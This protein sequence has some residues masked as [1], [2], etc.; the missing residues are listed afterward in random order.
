[1]NAAAA[2]ADF[3]VAV[4]GAGPAGVATATGLARLGW[5]VCV[6]TAA[7]REG[8]EGASERTLELLR[9][10]GLSSALASITVRGPRLRDWAGVQ[11]ET[12]YE[13]RV[14]RCR[15][16][17][18]LRED[19][20]AVAELRLERVRTVRREGTAWV[21]QTESGELRVRA[22]VEARGR[23]VRE[24][25]QRGPRLLS[26]SHRYRG[27]GEAG[28]AVFMGA[29]AWYW[30]A[31]DGAGDIQLQMVSAPRASVDARA[32][33]PRATSFLRAGTEMPAERLRE[34]SLPS[35]LQ[36]RLGAAR[37]L[38]EVRAC[39]AGASCRA[40]AEF[41]GRV[42]AGDAALALEPLSGHGLYEALVGAPAVVA[43][44]NTWLRGEPWAPVR[45]FLS[46]RVQESWGR[47]LAA[48]GSFYAEAAAY[49][50]TAFWSDT[51]RGYATL[52]AKVVARAA[53]AGDA[54]TPRVQVRP[55]LNGSRIEQ[56]R[57]LVG[58]SWPRGIWCH[59]DIELAALLDSAERADWDETRTAMQLGRTPAAVHNVLQWLK[60]HDALPA[61]G[62]R[63]ALRA[64]VGMAFAYERGST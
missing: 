47:K 5:S 59:G 58:A 62:A 48:A 56:R 54:A 22:L 15:F 36:Q 26:V 50:D 14:E 16:D 53:P 25:A 35:A 20:R 11:A 64:G 31:C 38:G 6:L 17:T 32:E 2:R 34:A 24:A 12:G 39:A 57:V 43:A 27:A 49:C 19:A 7:P 30:L 28:S 33:R 42:L 51:A 61:E 40:P 8:V 41:E 52:A 23:R 46:E 10:Q 1:M 18:A 45:Q 3:D 21:V 63:Q 44:I 4:L 37:A 55:V 29:D 60:A 9:R 13:Y